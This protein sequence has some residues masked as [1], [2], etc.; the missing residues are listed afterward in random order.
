M[1]DN[2]PI[3]YSIM[4]LIVDIIIKHIDGWSTTFD[5]F[6]VQV[7]FYDSIEMWDYSFLKLL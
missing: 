1:K 6:N 3:K 5:I 7:W 2:T 4:V